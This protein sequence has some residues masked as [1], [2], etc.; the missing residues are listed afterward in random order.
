[1]SPASVGPLPKY[2]NHG[3]MKTTWEIPNAIFSCA[4][5]VA[6]ECGIPFRA[7]VPEAPADKVRAQG[8]RDSKPRMKTSANSVTGTRKRPEL[9]ESIE[10]ALDQ[11]ETEDRQ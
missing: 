10:E 8:D 9:T 4:K 3:F 7:L 1:M 11:I 6:A 5:T 2:G